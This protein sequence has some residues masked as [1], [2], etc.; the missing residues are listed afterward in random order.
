MAGRMVLSY[1]T[2]RLVHAFTQ[3]HAT[4]AVPVSVVVQAVDVAGAVRMA[5][6]NNNSAEQNGWR[7]K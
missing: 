7:Y 1:D 5:V 3:L 2:T 4:R 6:M